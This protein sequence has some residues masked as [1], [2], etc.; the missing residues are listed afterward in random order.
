MV[1]PDGSPLTYR[2]ATH[3]VERPHWKDAEDA[4]FDRLLDKARRPL[5]PVK[6]T[7][8]RVTSVGATM[9]RIVSQSMCI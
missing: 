6:T 5:V 7:V 4:E 2:T 1:N 3:G 8:E 9:S